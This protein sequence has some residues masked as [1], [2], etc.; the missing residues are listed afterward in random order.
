MNFSA[1]PVRERE[2]LRYAGCSEPS[3]ELLDMLRECRELAE[4]VLEYKVCF[5]ELEASVCGDICDFSE[6]SLRSSDLA[7]NL[8]GCERVLLFGATLGVGIDRL[9]GKYSSLSPAR[10]LIFQAI[11]AERIEA[12]CDEFCSS[13]ARTRDVRLKP[14]FSAGYGDLSIETQKAIFESL[15]CQKNI[16]LFLNASFSMSPSKSVTAFVGIKH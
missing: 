4:P 1:P 13:Y 6:F 15:G 14:R 11:G 2:I 16:G 8:R 12:L 9:I 10:A 3:Q 5:R 7:K